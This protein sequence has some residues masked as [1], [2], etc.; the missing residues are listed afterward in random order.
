MCGNA[1][2]IA[3]LLAVLLHGGTL[4]IALLGHGQHFTI[5]I[6][7]TSVD[8]AMSLLDLHAADA[9]GSQPHT[10]HITFAKANRVARTCNQNDLFITCCL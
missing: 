9:S 3:T 8:D 2:S 7:N 1:S 4:G 5:C 6:D 10:A